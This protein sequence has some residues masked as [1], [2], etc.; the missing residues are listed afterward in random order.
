LREKALDAFGRFDIL[1][2]NAG[3]GPKPG[4]QL[5]RNTTGL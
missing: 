5:T 1:V 4:P 2:N 3:V